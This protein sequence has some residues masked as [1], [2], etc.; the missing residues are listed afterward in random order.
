VEQVLSKWE[1]EHPE[2][3]FVSFRDATRRGT[4]ILN[5][6]GGSEKLR[7][8]EYNAFICHAGEDKKDVAE[9]LA[10]LLMQ[11]GLNVWL[12]EFA[13]RVGDSLR[14]KIDYGLAN[15]RYGIVILS[16]FF[17]KKNWPQ[18]ELDGL[19]AREDSEGHKVILPVW[20]DVDRDYV[21][22]YSP[23]LADKLASNTNKGMQTV[24]AELLEA[25]SESTTPKNQSA[26][27]DPGLIP[28]DRAVAN[29]DTTVVPG[30]DIDSDT[31]HMFHRYFD[32]LT[33][34][35]FKVLEF[36]DDPR[37]Y[38]T[39][40]SVIFGNYMGGAVST[41]LEEAVPELRG[42]RGFYDQL[43]RDLYARGLL[44]IDE[45]GIHVMMTETG[46]YASRTTEAGKKFLVFTNQTRRSDTSNAQQISSL[47]KSANRLLPI[48]SFRLSPEV[49]RWVG[50][51]TVALM[52]F[53]LDSEMLIDIWYDPHP[54][55]PLAPD[56]SGGPLAIDQFL[57]ILELN[58]EMRKY[59]FGITGRP[60]SILVV[61][62]EGDE[63]LGYIGSYKLLES[64]RGVQGDQI[65]KI[66]RGLT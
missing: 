22:K 15:S 46:M 28:Q 11:K 53:W 32:D 45:T 26:Q 37:G 56:L 30:L 64:L 25:I 43:V 4:G 29:A 52:V 3:L 34:S 12:D 59:E 44:N 66:I 55:F 27:E 17:F 40:H 58:P 8:F 16:P 47:K 41:I 31:E 10:K 7:S 5:K 23:T 65:R 36:F 51:D 6:P 54:R 19:T 38:G 24:L 14:Q 2:S 60:S 49:A 62:F 1:K 33:P 18:R 13:L 39:R 42:R 63:V 50:R 48:R 35:H 20:H 57:S 21:L 9:P 61:L